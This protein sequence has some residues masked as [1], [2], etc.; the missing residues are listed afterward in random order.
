[1]Y[2]VCIIHEIIES[3]V[4][5]NGFLDH[6]ICIVDST[7]VGQKQDRRHKIA[8]TFI[9]SSTLALSLCV[10]MQDHEKILYPWKIFPSLLLKPR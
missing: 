10:S 2:A 7:Y 3:F 1:M 5:N 6:R 8:G 9:I 4:K